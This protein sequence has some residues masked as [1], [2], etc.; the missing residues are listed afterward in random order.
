MHDTSKSYRILLVE[1][2]RTQATSL[3]D[4][5][6]TQGWAVEWV[7]SAEAAMD[8][9][10]QAELDLVV[11]D[12]FL[13][14]MRG[15]ALCR[16]I[17]L[18]GTAR[19]LPV[20]VLTAEDTGAAEVHLFECGADD[21]VPKS[22]DQQI[23]LAR[24]RALLG[25]PR[26]RSPLRDPDAPLVS[27]RILTIDDSATFQEYLG[28]ELE[29]EGYQVMRAMSGREGLELLARESFDCAIV[30]LAMPEL[31]GIEVCRRIDE[32]R[33]ASGNL[34]AV[35]MLTGCENKEE[36]TRALA[37]GADDFVGKS[38][39]LAVLKSRI[40]ALLRRKFLQEEN[41]AI[42]EKLKATEV[43]T[44]RTRAA[45]EVAEAKARLNDEL[46][47]RVQQRTAE[48]AAANRDLAEKTRE[49]EAFVY[50]V[51]HD[52]RSPLVN[53]QGFSKEL[54]NSC[55]DLREIIAN[56]AVP[57]GT[58]TKCAAL[59]DG[60]MNEAIQFIQSAVMRLS[61]NIDA[62]LRL[63]R[64][65][66][67]ELELQNVAVR[68]IVERV[69]EA[70]ADTIQKRKAVV[71]TGALPAAW[72]DPMAVEQIFANLIGNAVNYLSP[73]RDGTVEVGMLADESAEGA[74]QTFHT[75]SVRD[76]GVGIPK[77][78]AAKVFQIFQRMHP[79]LAKGEGVGLAL[80]RRV[81]ERLG[82]KIWFDST[83]DVGTTFFVTLPAA[84]DVDVDLAAPAEV[85]AH[86]NCPAEMAHA[87]A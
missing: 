48:L 25:K 4:S 33:R 79:K 72:A 28:G 23:I 53:L 47:L 8:R 71:R 67:V 56:P 73:E 1:D 68:P 19:D 59:I 2:S 63:S 44:L 55:S 39:D 12:Y 24:I 3:V 49:N 43:E 22:T 36:L 81:V 66:R 50:S 78:C 16:R 86:S 14:G 34:L 30:D 18:S 60:E 31:D 35:L 40:R 83:P 9:I 57:D 21:F 46:E 70:M 77:A 69:V 29:Q 61:T 41:R 45:M 74:K 13:P 32:L 7:C 84:A 64:I 20:L 42:I 87:M 51:S 62:L 27:A 26:S 76:N 52:L 6:S 80:V 17:R 11:L 5:L 58:R 54:G 65:G 85:E 38:S 82:G 75:F 15:D 10:T 37:V